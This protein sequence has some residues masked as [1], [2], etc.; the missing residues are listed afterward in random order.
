MKLYKKFSNLFDVNIIKQLSNKDML[1]ASSNKL[2]IY[3]IN[4]FQSLYNFSEI[5]TPTIYIDDIQEIQNK[6]N[7]EIILAIN[8]SN[9]KVQ[10][11]LIKMNIKNKKKYNHKLLRELDFSNLKFKF[12]K[13]ICI[14]SFLDSLIISINHIIYYYKN[15]IELGKYNLIKIEEYKTKDFLIVKGITTLKHKDNNFII[16]IELKIESLKSYYSLRIY[17]FENFELLTEIKDL[18]LSLQKVHLSFMTFLNINKP[19]LLIGDTYD[20]LLIIK[21]YSDFDIYDEICLTKLIKEFASNNSNKSEN[22][23]IKSICG[24]NDGT[25]VI[26]ILYKLS[27]DKNE[28]TNYMIRGRINFKTRKFELIGINDNA[29]NNKTNFITSS[30]MIQGNNNNEGYFLISGDHEGVLKIWKF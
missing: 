12:P 17:Y 4:T 28:K 30:L 5:K 26:C 21:L 20:K 6:R 7:S 8:L 18:N 2:K 25:F 27:N 13:I 11:L 19:Y 3:S 14:H 29:H 1:I 23:E 10:I 16:T 9:F 15:N 22:Y 24:L